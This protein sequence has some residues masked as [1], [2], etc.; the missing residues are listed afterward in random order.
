M[1]A[2]WVVPTAERRLGKLLTTAFPCLVFPGCAHL[3]SQ[4]F[5]LGLT[6][7]L[8]LCTQ[9]PSL[10]SPGSV[11]S[12]ST[13][14]LLPSLCVVFCW[15]SAWICCHE[16]CNFRP[17]EEVSINP[18]QNQE[19]KKFQVLCSQDTHL[20][21]IAERNPSIS[22]KILYKFGIWTN[23]QLGPT[24]DSYLHVLEIR[25]GFWRSCPCSLRIQFQEQLAQVS[26]Q[27]SLHL[28]TQTL[29]FGTYKH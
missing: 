29:S 23:C 7:S 16:C 20:Q 6:S 3:T 19:G 8:V 18:L 5:L 14:H 1:P 24:A 13:C 9:P 27:S 17:A 28:M 26:C 2:S 4:L 22:A 11:C 25:S 15:C 12:L 21:N 10:Y